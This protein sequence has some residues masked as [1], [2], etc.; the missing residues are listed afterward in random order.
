MIWRLYTPCLFYCLTYL[1]LVCFFLGVV[2]ALFVPD[3]SDAVDNRCA[4]W[5]IVMINVYLLHS[6]KCV[7]WNQIEMKST[8][9]SIPLIMIKFQLT[10]FSL[11]SAGLYFDLQGLFMPVFCLLFAH[12][13]FTFKIYLNRNVHCHKIYRE[14]RIMTLCIKRNYKFESQPIK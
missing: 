12:I 3:P 8:I 5:W 11:H 2:M 7:S 14:G 6:Q 4:K 10:P 13:Y 9:Y 1:R